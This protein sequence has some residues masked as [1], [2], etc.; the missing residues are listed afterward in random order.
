MNKF[1]RRG[2][3]WSWLSTL[4]LAFHLPAMAFYIPDPPAL[5]LISPKNGATSTDLKPVFTW[6]SNGAL[7][8]KSNFDLFVCNSPNFSYES[9]NCFRFTGEPN[10][11]GINEHQFINN[12]DPDTQYYWRL[13]YCS[14]SIYDTCPVSEI[15]TFHT[16]GSPAPDALAGLSLH[17][18]WN[19]V[20]AT[21]TLPAATFMSQTNIV[22][23]WMWNNNKWAVLIPSATDGGAAYASAHGLDLLSSI[24]PGEG[25]WVNVSDL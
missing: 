15:W 18:G 4:M 14:G 25:F 24:N 8:N 11:C 17:K 7:W 12:L 1:I 6:D 2:L 16:T 23:V 20:G 10:A 3:R 19:L 22:S 5:I 13:R 9:D 21:V